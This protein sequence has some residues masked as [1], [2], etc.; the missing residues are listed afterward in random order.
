MEHVNELVLENGTVNELGLKME[1]E[2]ALIAINNSLHAVCKIFL[3]TCNSNWLKKILWGS[4]I[5]EERWKFFLRTYPQIKL[6]SGTIQGHCNLP[7]AHCTSRK[8]F[9]SIQE[10]IQ[11]HCTLRAAFCRKYFELDTCCFK[12][13]SNASWSADV[14]IMNYL[15]VLPGILLLLFNCFDFYFF[16]CF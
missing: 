13:D 1:I 10:T 11:G 3:S 7:L 2:L 5:F 15:K 12:L 8:Y 6:L 4:W 9:T 16:N 14:Y